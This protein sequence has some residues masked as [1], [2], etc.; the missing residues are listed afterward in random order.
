MRNCILILLFCILPVAAISQNV[1][2]KTNV[3]YDATA[4]INA[5]VEF[6]VGRKMTVD[7]SGNYNAWNFS[8][9]KKWRHILVQPEL[10]YW[11]CEKMNGHFFGVHAHWMK[12]NIGN[13]KMPFGLWKETAHNR[14]QG[15]LWGGGLTYGYAFLI[16]EHINVEALVGVGYGRVIFDKY[17]GGNCGTVILSDKKDYFG[18][19]KLALNLVYVF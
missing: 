19:T 18:P 9:N 1:S 16:T 4:S 2:V 6:S 8:G 11:L 17:P 14:F 10:R 12:F 15:D 3:I 5:G 13:V 7:L